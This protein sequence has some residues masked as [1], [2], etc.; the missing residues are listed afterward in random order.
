MRVGDRKRATTIIALLAAGGTGLSGC[1]SPFLEYPSDLGKN[2]SPET[3]RSVDRV[4]LDRFRKA[5]P[6]VTPTD[7][8]A[9]A[10]KRFD[11]NRFA[12]LEKMELSLDQVR[13]SALEHNLDLKVVSFDPT[14]S[15]ENLNQ[16]RAKF[17]SAFTARGSWG[18]FDQPTAS[19]LSSAQ[20]QNIQLEPGV[21]IPLRTGGTATVTLPMQRN[22][23]NNQ[24]S[25]LNPS[26]TTDVQFSVSHELLRNAGRSANNASIRIA[27]YNRQATE[28]RTKLEV[29]RQLAAADR[30]YWRLYQAR[31]ELEV[32]QKQYELANEQL[33]RAKRRVAG[34]AAA[35]IEVTRSEAGLAERLESIILAENAV[36]QRQRELKKVMNMPGL[37]IDTQTVVV[38]T[39]PPDPVEYEFDAERAVQA[40]L[41]NRMELLELELRLAADAVTIEY[42]K[43][44]ALPS[45]ALDY[46]YRVNGLDGSFGDSWERAARNNYEDWQLGFAADVPLWNER[47][48]AAVRQSILQRLQRLSS[49]ES[50]ELAIR[51]E[52]LD[53]LDTIRTGWQR[54]L[55]ARQA[56]I[57]AART[58]QA[59]QR[60]F[61]VGASTSTDVL[62]A[63]ASL[64]DA[65]SA[66]V[67]ALA[68]YQVSQ[69]D[70]AFAA[71]VLLGASRVEWAPAPGVTGNEPT[72]TDLPND[73]PPMT[74]NGEPVV[75]PAPPGAEPVKPAEPGSGQS[76]SGQAGS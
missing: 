61:D 43:N 29:I 65:Q 15:Q 12:K 56:S 11:R 76:G 51:Q 10:A 74:E 34:G 50:R 8:E 58:L 13:E 42:N 64:A 3:F 72:P 39:T 44:Q 9:A 63:A 47:A 41:T 55:A 24:F 1:Q 68:D 18:E 31:G 54:I 37:D 67:R 57:L 46:T 66:E 30:A 59:E 7:V 49:R 27:N 48:R 75:V 22:R 32:R 71:G 14:I 16:E 19:T 45:F 21:R 69:V 70:L 26:Y 62:D 2:L 73:R 17:E 40:A 20:S 38:P 35:E 53:A 36:V 28:A 25:T 33:E 6:T 5:Q 60:Q 52:T 4:R 23:N